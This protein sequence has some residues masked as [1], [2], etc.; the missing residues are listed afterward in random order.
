MF[1]ELLG[2]QSVE[3]N[4]QM[5]GAIKEDKFYANILA[6]ATLTGCIEKQKMIKLAQQ[7][8][9]LEELVPALKKKYLEFAEVE[10]GLKE[11][12]KFVR[13]CQEAEIIRE[14]RHVEKNRQQQEQLEAVQLQLQVLQLHQEAQDNLQRQER[15]EQQQRYPRKEERQYDEKVKEGDDDPS[16]ACIICL[17]NKR[18][19]VIRPCKHLC[20]CISC[21]AF[22]LDQCPQCRRIITAIERLYL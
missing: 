20:L 11:Q 17:E 14:Q 4:K 13:R 21:A 2:Q 7:I 6:Q 1:D 12:E 10:E 15:L 22:E 16:S 19:C 18:V 8:D 9:E 5:L 3:T